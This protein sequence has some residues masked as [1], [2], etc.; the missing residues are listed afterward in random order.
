M[1]FLGNIGNFPAIINWWGY[2]SLD[3]R[4]VFDFGSSVFDKET[5]HSC[6]DLFVC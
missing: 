6:P 5:G 3:S 4:G 1:F 2:T